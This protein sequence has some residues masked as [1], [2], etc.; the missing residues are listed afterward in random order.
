MDMVYFLSSANHF[1]FFL[2]VF[3]YCFSWTNKIVVFI[4]MK[5]CETNS[6]C[7][8][9]TLL[10]ELVLSM[11]WWRPSLMDGWRFQSQTHDR[12]AAMRESGVCVWSTVDGAARIGYGLAASSCENAKHGGDYGQHQDQTGNRNGY[13]ETALRDAQGVVR[14]LQRKQGTNFC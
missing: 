10:L 9:I 7:L 2:I 12:L 8:G 14:I 5:Y 1:F 11:Q 3:F 13:G 4:G 6:Q